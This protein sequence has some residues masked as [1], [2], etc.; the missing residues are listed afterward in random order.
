MA[1]FGTWGMSPSSR[2]IGMPGADELPYQY[3]KENYIAAGRP[4]VFSFNMNE[5]YTYAYGTTVVH[6]SGEQCDMSFSFDPEPGGMYEATFLIIGNK[7]A[8]EMTQIIQNKD[9]TISR[10]PEPSF[11]KLEKACK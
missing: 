6:V 8:A 1:T 4:F 3:V 2:R 11:K 5:S 7:C 10:V 9:M